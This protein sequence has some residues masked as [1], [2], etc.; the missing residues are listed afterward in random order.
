MM[1]ESDIERMSSISGVRASIE[2]RRMYLEVNVGG[3]D[4]FE[5]HISGICYPLC[6]ICLCSFDIVGSPHAV[7]SRRSIVG[8]NFLVSLSHSVMEA[9]WLTKSSVRLA[10]SC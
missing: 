1:F 8:E 2:H 4:E 6:L 10:T 5:V 9:L 7:K 3:T